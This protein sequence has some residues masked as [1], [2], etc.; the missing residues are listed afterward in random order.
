MKKG[1]L[2]GVLIAFTAVFSFNGK[3]AEKS[4]P[5]T[6]NLYF[7]TLQKGDNPFKDAL[8]FNCVDVCKDNIINFS[9]NTNTEGI[10]TLKFAKEFIGKQ[11]AYN[12]VTSLL[13]NSTNLS[14]ITDSDSGIDNCK[15]SFTANF[16]IWA[17][18]YYGVSW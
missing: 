9:G 10:Y 16:S 15:N 4:P 7:A 6:T 11:G 12:Y 5:P 8:Y 3:V 18:A 1:F 2:I 17:K 13:I 14:S